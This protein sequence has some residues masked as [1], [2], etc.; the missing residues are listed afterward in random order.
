MFQYFYFRN[1]PEIVKKK[2]SVGLQSQILFRKNKTKLEKN[3][4]AIFTKPSLQEK[5]PFVTL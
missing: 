4:M 1:I 3:L 2:K 5:V